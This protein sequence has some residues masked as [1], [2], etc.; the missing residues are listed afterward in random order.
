ML[1]HN[2]RVLISL[3][4]S[5]L[6]V[7]HSNLILF[8]LSCVYFFHSVI[9]KMN[10]AIKLIEPCQTIAKPFLI[11]SNSFNSVNLLV[12]PQ[13]S[14]LLLL[15]FEWGA[16]S[17]HPQQGHMHLWLYI[18]VLT[19]QQKLTCCP[20]TNFQLPKTPGKKAF[21]Q[22][23]ATTF[24]QGENRACPTIT[25]TSLRIL[26]KKPDSKNNLHHSVLPK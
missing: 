15:S 8:Q 7:N 26:V 16:Y 13:L 18:A 22:L 14:I 20:I 24:S 9:N 3:C 25:T 17:T 12:L 10:F 4:I 1:W 11:P 23:C 2:M 19:Q 6:H 21:T 5:G